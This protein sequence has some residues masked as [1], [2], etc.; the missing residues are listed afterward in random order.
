MLNFLVLTDFSP[1]AQNALQYAVA[2]AEKMTAHITLL[3]IGNNS[4]NTAHYIAQLAKEKEKYESVKHTSIHILDAYG[5]FLVTLQDFLA[6]NS[7]NYLFVG[8]KG[9]RSLDTTWLGL[10]DLDKI[11]K[12]WLG[13]HTVEVIENVQIPIIVVPEKSVLLPLRQIVLSIDTQRAYNPETFLPLQEIATQHQSH[14]DIVSIRLRSEVKDEDNETLQ[15]RKVKKWLGETIPCSLRVILAD[16]VYE[17]LRYYLSQVQKENML[18]MVTRKKGF[19]EKI[20]GIS[21]TQQ[22]VY[23]AE[24]P[25]LVL[26]KK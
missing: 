26:H 10:K 14:V 6:H 16:G 1:T 25:V 23:A 4:E 9:L 11:E 24:L 7:I 13:S 12:F 21:A 19:F 15:L 18:V 3:H 22:M 8:M 17:G 20:F 2:L 5:N